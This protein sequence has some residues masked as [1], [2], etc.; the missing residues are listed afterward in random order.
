[1]L[2]AIQAGING[3]IKLG[4]ATSP[5]GRL[6]NIQ[7]SSVERLRL[8]GVADSARTAETELHTRFA[9]DRIGAEWFHPT[10]ELLA[11][12]ASWGASGAGREA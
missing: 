3:P 7:A 10:A 11:E 8:L 12:I 4:H 2:Y 9:A 5:A 6:R 1:M